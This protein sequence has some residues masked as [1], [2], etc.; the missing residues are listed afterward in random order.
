MKSDN[1]KKL[2]DKIEKPDYEQEVLKRLQ[3]RKM[4]TA[5]LNEVSYYILKKLIDILNIL[6]K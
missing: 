3:E 6:K 1:I 4:S 5:E 2:D